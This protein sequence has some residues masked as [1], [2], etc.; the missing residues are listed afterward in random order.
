MPTLDLPAN[1]ITCE[2]TIPNHFPGPQK[3]SPKLSSRPEAYRPPKYLHRALSQPQIRRQ[4]D[5]PP[6]AKM[7][8]A[9]SALLSKS[10]ERRRR[11][12][13]C[14]QSRRDLQVRM[15][16]NYANTI[17]PVSASMLLTTASDSTW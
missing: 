15:R 16:T 13:S 5:P 4:Y 11:E 8:Q 17:V 10:S 1:S 3:M 12:C 14:V 9:P 6:A 2:Y 7:R